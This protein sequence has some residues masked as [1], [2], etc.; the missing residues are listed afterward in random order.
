MKLQ[1]EKDFESGQLFHRPLRKSLTLT[2]DDAER[3]PPPAGDSIK[4]SL[5]ASQFGFRRFSGR[6]CCTLLL[7]VRKM[8]RTAAVMIVKT[9]FLD[10]S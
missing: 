3:K 1:S 7:Y 2:P 8:F 6:D 10:I 9:D 4:L 5:S